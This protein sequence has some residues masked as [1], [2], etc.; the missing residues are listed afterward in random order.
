MRRGQGVVLRS[1]MKMKR[2]SLSDLSRPLKGVKAFPTSA[3]RILPSHRTVI[4][5]PERP[6]LACRRLRTSCADVTLALAAQGVPAATFV[7][8]GSF[9]HPREF[10]RILSIERQVPRDNSTRF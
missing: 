10:C 7:R 4:F 1:R 8:I 9:T 3:P 5:P 2:F 6:E